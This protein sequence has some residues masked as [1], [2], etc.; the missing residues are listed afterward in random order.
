MTRHEI[1]QFAMLQTVD[2]LL[3][4]NQSLF[5]GQPALVAAQARLHTTIGTVLGL[6]PVQASAA[7]SNTA[8]KEQQKQKVIDLFLKVQAGVLAHATATSDAKLKEDVTI[9]ESTF[10][11]LRQSDMQTWM[12]KVY[13]LAAPIV[14][15]LASW[16]VTQADIEDLK[17][18]ADGFRQQLLDLTSTKNLSKEATAAIKSELKAGLDFLNEHLDNLMLPYKSLQPTFY[19][20]YGV[21][22]EIIDR[23]ATH[24][25]GN[26]ATAS[27]SVATK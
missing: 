20:Q 2:A 4:N 16:G 17:S 7:G 24:S 18:G 9:P 23:A 19:T 25:K 12:L 27:G 15:L 22:R 26:D 1:D 5:Q 10:K 21:A 6:A 3:S 11:K 8:A 13:G 14:A